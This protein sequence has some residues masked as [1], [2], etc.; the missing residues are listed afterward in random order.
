MKKPLISIIIP[1]YNSEKYIEECLNSILHQEYTNWEAVVVN[2]G[3]TDNTAKICDSFFARDNRFKIIHKKNEGANYA[4]RDGVLNSSGEYITSVDSDDIA[5]PWYLSVL[6]N[7]LVSN[8]ADISS[9]RYRQSLPFCK[10]SNKTDVYKG[11][12]DILE[13]F[14]ASKLQGNLYATLS[15]KELF[16]DVDWDFSNRHYDEC[17]Y[18]TIQ[19]YCGAN[20]AVSSDAKPYYYRTV[21]NSLSK[22][23]EY[24]ETDGKISDSFE[25]VKKTKLDWEKYFQGLGIK[26]PAQLA[27]RNLSSYLAILSVAVDA[28]YSKKRV[29]EFIDY[30]LNEYKNDDGKEYWSKRSKMLLFILRIGKSFAF[31]IY[32]KTVLFTKRIL[33]K[34]K[35]I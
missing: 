26:M 16:T 23:I 35:K 33:V 8:N 19:L 29:K 28:K 34:V 18:L 15:K 25:L 6:Y 3:S 4:R 12:Y 5:A 21:S 22:N 20:V 32:R 1:A 14:L 9:C 11:K 13:A 30:I 10:E 24:Q 7:N 2:D 17:A 27:A 31:K